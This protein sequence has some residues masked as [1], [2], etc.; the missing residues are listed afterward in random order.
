[1]KLA[2]GEKLTNHTKSNMSA[3][4]NE[5]FICN[6]TELKSMHISFYTVWW[7]EID[8]YNEG[9]FL[10]YKKFRLYCGKSVKYVSVFIAMIALNEF[11]SKNIKL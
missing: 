4:R 10:F 3:A 6:V 11:L 9:K 7:S 2:S 1:M 5:F 8:V